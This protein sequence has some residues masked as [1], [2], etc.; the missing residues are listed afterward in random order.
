MAARQLARA[1]FEV[2]T[3][4]DAVVALDRLARAAEP[5]DVIVTDH[6]MPGMTGLDLARELAG[7]G[8]RP[9]IVLW[10][11]NRDAADAQALGAVD[12]V[13]DKPAVPGALAAEVQRLVDR[14]RALAAE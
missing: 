9:P 10:T 6:A 14:T 11:G 8:R 5:P 2:E 1:G 3:A 12:A 7:R 13:L 4:P